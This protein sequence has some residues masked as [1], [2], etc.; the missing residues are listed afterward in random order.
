MVLKFNSRNG[1]VLICNL[2]IFCNEKNPVAAQKKEFDR[3]LLY[4][5]TAI[6]CFP[7]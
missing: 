2:T 6:Y 1:K 4:L 3:V 5:F 7:E